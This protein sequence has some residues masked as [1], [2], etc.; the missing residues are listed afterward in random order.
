[1]LTMAKKSNENSMKW[2]KCLA[3]WFRWVLLKGKLLFQTLSDSLGSRWNWENNR[4]T[5]MRPEALPNARPCDSQHNCVLLQGAQCLP[6]TGWQ[7]GWCG[8]WVVWCVICWLIMWAIPKE[9]PSYTFKLWRVGH[10]FKLNM[11]LLANPLFSVWNGLLQTH[12]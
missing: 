5:A 12:C 1:M 9:F 8:G 2:G 7:G 10:V 6:L 3:E 11:L 4:H